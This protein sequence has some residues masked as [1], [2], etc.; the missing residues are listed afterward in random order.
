MFDLKLREQLPNWLFILFPK[1]HTNEN[2]PDEER[3]IWGFFLCILFFLAIALVLVPVFLLIE[4]NF[5]AALSA[6]FAGIASALLRRLHR[7]TLDQMGSYMVWAGYLG[8]FSGVIA[9]PLGVYNPVLG[10]YHLL[11]LL[12]TIFVPSSLYRLGGA[13]LALYLFFVCY[14]LLGIDYYTPAPAFADVLL[15]ALWLIL[16]IFFMRFIVRS[17]ISRSERI[18]YQQKELLRYRDSLEEIVVQRTMELEESRQEAED[19]K[20]AAEAASR[21]KSHFLANMSHEFR[22][23]LNAIIGY[24][25]LVSELLEEIDEPSAEI[26][27]ALHDVNAINHSGTHLL[28]VINQVL[29]LSKI[30]EERIKPSLYWTS[31]KQILDH[32]FDV[33]TPLAQQKGLSFVCRDN[34]S[35]DLQI[36]TDSTQVSQ[37]LVNLLGNAVKFTESGG[38]SVTVSETAINERPFVSFEIEDTGIGMSPEMINNVFKPFWQAEMSYVRHYSGTGLGLTISNRLCE[39]LNG[40]ISLTSEQGVGTKFVVMLPVDSLNP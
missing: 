34:F 38:V 9:S 28:S 16:S 12:C 4:R 22:T 21:A 27:E 14:P 30:E 19:A 5:D 8:V 20:V 3:S 2:N 11:L 37:I 39:G 31:L 25:E 6:L 26:D 40:R 18:Q 24:S 32:T 13:I 15:G 7:F 33:I 23:P 1:P 29:D 17:L 35:P 10:L 36:L